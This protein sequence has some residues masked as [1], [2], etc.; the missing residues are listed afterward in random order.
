MLIEKS[1]SIPFLRMPGKFACQILGHF[2]TDR[3]M[4]SVYWKTLLL[5]HFPVDSGLRLQLNMQH[6]FVGFHVKDAL[7]FSYWGYIDIW[8]GKT[9][10]TG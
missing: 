9:L 7:V 5:F 2:I 6:M 4:K 10:L 1:L 3:K 8:Y